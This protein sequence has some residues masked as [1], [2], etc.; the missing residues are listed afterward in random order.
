MPRLACA[1]VLSPGL[2]SGRWA[3]LARFARPPLARNRGSRFDLRWPAIGG[4]VSTSDG[5]NRGSWVWRA[6]AARS[7]G[8]WSGHGA[9]RCT[10]GSIQ[11]WR[12]FEA[13]YRAA[14]SLYVSRARANIRPW[15]L[16]SNSDLAVFAVF[17]LRVEG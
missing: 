6:A 15:R 8:W 9:P 17:W 3:R 12:N 2:G 4:R 11:L 1:S 13:G 10:S 14:A 16:S 7:P 5:R